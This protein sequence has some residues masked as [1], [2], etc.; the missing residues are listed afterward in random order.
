MTRCDKEKF[1]FLNFLNKK[2][3]YLN[4]NAIFNFKI[5]YGVELNLCDVI[6]VRALLK[7]LVRVTKGE[8]DFQNIEIPRDIFYG[9]SPIYLLIYLYTWSGRGQSARRVIMGPPVS[10]VPLAAGQPI[11]THAPHSRAPVWVTR[12]TELILVL[13]VPP[14]N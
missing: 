12:M 1:F 2:N 13:R 4:L 5:I 14:D 10:Q 11:W 6:F 8:R 9:W 3:I 7:V